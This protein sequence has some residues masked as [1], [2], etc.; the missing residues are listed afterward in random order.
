MTKLTRSDGHL[1]AE[2]CDHSLSVVSGGE[3]DLLSWCACADRPVIVAAEALGD[4]NV[5]SE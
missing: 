2:A 4:Q 3:F 1:D 5:L